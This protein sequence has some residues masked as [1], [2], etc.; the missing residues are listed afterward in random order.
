[1]TRA[2]PSRWR[3]GIAVRKNIHRLESRK[4]KA[5]AIGEISEGGARE[6]V[7]ALAFQYG[8]KLLAQDVQMQHVRCGIGELSFAQGLGSPIGRLLLLGDL[9]VQQ[10]ARQVL[11][12]VPVGVGPRDF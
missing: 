11:E 9:D 7:P 5:D 10:L 2:A 8:V 4:I 3:L 6:S 1:M 12:S